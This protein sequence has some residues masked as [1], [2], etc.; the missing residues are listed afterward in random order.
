MHLDH[1]QKIYK[2]IGTI[3]NHNKEVMPNIRT[4]LNGFDRGFLFLYM[5]S[6]NIGAEIGVWKGE[7]SSA[8]LTH[9]QPKQ[10]H[11]IDAWIA[12]PNA[13]GVMKE[14]DGQPGAEEERYQHVLQLFSTQIANDQIVIH[15]ELSNIAATKFPDNFF[16]W[17]YIDAGHTYEDVKQDLDLYV[18]KVKIGGYIM[19][20]DY[21][22]HAWPGVV[23]AVDELRAMP[24]IR[25]VS[26]TSC[27]SVLHKVQ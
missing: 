8:I 27:Q 4:S 6:G 13:S 21:N 10:L 1:T 18:P 16:D 5:K 26:L 2:Q 20:D 22:P 12:Y 24:H 15:R 7:L 23:Q 25:T 11:L 17:I 3:L 19:G 9:T 14:K